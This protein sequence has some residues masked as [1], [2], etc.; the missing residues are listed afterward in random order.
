MKTAPIM[1]PFSHLAEAV[2]FELTEGD[3]PSVLFKSTAL[4]H[5][6][7]LPVICRAPWGLRKRF[8]QVAETINKNP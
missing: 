8:P 5:S 7:T 4:N 3:K 2:R 6:A 1:G